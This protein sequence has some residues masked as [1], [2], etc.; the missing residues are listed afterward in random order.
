MQV[1]ITTTSPKFSGIFEFIFDAKEK[2]HSI[3]KKDSNENYYHFIEDSKMVHTSENDIK[4]HF[5]QF[6]ENDAYDCF[7]RSLMHCGLEILLCERV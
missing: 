1:N 6:I 7:E 2:R 3:T 5:L 4:N